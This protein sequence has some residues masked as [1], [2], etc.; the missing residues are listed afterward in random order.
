MN[1]SSLES[2]LKQQTGVVPAHPYDTAWI[3]LVPDVNDPAQPAW[4]QALR[5]LRDTQLADG[6]WGHEHV[7]YAHGRT[8]STLAALRA[9]LFWGNPEDEARIA[10]GVNALLDYA[11]DMTSEPYEPAGFELLL[12]RL[13]KEV[14][15]WQLNLPFD[16]WA[17]YE[18]M[19]TQ[20][21]ALIG[22]LWPEYDAPRSWWFSMEMLPEERLAAI[23][24]H[25]LNAHGSVATSPAATAA[26]LRARR[27][28]GQDSP[29]AAAYI[30]EVLHV[31]KIGAGFC[32]PLE[33]FEIIWTLDILRRAGLEP[34]SSLLAP[35]IYKANRA[36][37][38][39]PQGMS[40]SQTFPIA[41]GDMTAVTYTVLS[42]AGLQ[43]DDYAFK[44]FWGPDNYLNYPDELVSSVSA[45]IHALASLRYKPGDRQYINMAER[46]T[47]WLREQMVNKGQF[48]DKWHFS[49]LYAT[50]R[51]VSV[52]A[53]WDDDL[54]C[55]CLEYL[56]KTQDKD[57]GWG[58]ATRV[59]LE[60]TSY[61]TLG[62]AAAYRTGLLRDISPLKR[63]DAYFKKHAYGNPIEAFWIGKTLFQPAGI[64]NAYIYGAR[65]ALAKLD[66]DY[67]RPSLWA[68]P[69]HPY[70]T[71]F[72]SQ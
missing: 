16:A 5:Y 46:I 38:T 55:K 53:N 19:T 35:L 49:S 58:R 43:P 51:A 33:Q 29:L 11:V 61:A 66:V 41:D 25:I 40:W 28:H 68:N 52:L 24:D 37:Q 14:K 39:S 59:N 13:V 57:G 32:Y 20:K 45:N 64:A 62:L 30:D 65:A 36:W 8:I 23:G 6:G 27:L 71:D 22:Q 50:S 34:S 15:Q 17:N 48:H 18:A 60:E 21:L 56:L 47:Y 9:L 67:Q 31:S 12:P 72:H 4:P 7:Y 63:A 70:F 3:A 69:S 44:R 54:A 10:A 26:Y 42:W 1:R 2:L